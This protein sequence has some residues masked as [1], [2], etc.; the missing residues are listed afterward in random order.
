M[1]LRLQDNSIRFRLTQSEVAAL[2]AGARV[3]VSVRFAAAPADP[4]IYS[5][6]TSAQCSEVRAERSEC[7][8]C[9]ILPHDLTRLW[10]TTSRVAIEHH[11]RIGPEAFLSISVE[12]DFRCLHS[13]RAADDA[14]NFPNPADTS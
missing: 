5:V 4:L 11:Q 1:K 7:E 2:A 9:V 12:K 13:G 6:E 3:E 8:I 10:A 14:D